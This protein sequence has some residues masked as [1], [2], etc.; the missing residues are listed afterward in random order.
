MSIKLTPSV[1]KINPATVQEKITTFI[2]DYVQK[3]G[4]SGGILGLSG[5]IDSSTTAAICAKALGGDKVLALILFD[6][7]SESS[8]IED[9][10]EVANLFGIR[11]RKI[12]ISSIIHQIYE[13]IPDYTYEDKLSAGNVRAR[14]RMVI[15]YYYSNLLKALVIGTSDRSELLTGYFT[16]YGDGAADI[17][18]LA[19]LYKTQVRMLAE[20]MN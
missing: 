2:R 3:S 8:D 4:A 19:G 5:G 1:L 12:G 15:L 10:E 14:V 11:F 6:E 7:F 18:P 20:H 9:A 17:A 16:K 13:T